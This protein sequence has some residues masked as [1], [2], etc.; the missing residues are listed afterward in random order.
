[1]ATKQ[2]R[3]GARA[4]AQAVLVDDLGCCAGSSSES[5]CVHKC[6]LCYP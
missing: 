1:M 4:V 6:R 5:C 3:T 2:Q